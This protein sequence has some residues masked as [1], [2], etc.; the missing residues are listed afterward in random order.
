MKE[1]HA[2]CEER[3][4]SRMGEKK[5]ERW[6]RDKKYKKL[7]I[8]R[9]SVV[10]PKG[11]K[12]KRKIPG[13][14]GKTQTFSNRVAVHSLGAQLVFVLLHTKDAFQCGNQNKYE[15]HPLPLCTSPVCGV[16]HKNCV[17]N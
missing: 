4:R 13:R 2:S 5:K 10:M 12:I 16:D 9:K 15:F 8:Q 11:K 3:R 7:G 1:H 6:G 17:C 14:G